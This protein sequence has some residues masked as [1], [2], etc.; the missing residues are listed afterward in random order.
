M[1]TKKVIYQDS[2]TTSRAANAL[3]LYTDNT[4]NL[5]DTRDQIYTPLALMPGCFT[6]GEHLKY[7][8]INELF[9]KA[10]NQFLAENAHDTDAKKL[11]QEITIAE[12]EQY[13][14]YYINGF[15]EW[16]I[17]KGFLPDLYKNNP[18]TVKRV[19][20]LYALVSYKKT[21][22]CPGYELYLTHY[23]NGAKLERRD[24]IEL[25][26]QWHEAVTDEMVTKEL[27]LN[28][29]SR[30]NKELPKGQKVEI[31]EY[32]YHYLLEV[33]PPNNWEGDYFEVGEPHHHEKGKAIHR[34]CWMEGDKYYTGYPFK[35]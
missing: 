5:V 18:W 11:I 35:R 4:P 2:G 9:Y 12:Q 13:F 17:E 22:G 16:L 25:I 33:L 7:R 27:E 8:I 1:K 30:W 3:I 15:Y 26:K 19:N 10:S 29:W 21:Q 20:E 24:E 14:T 23:Y 32:I 34:A 31:S 6:K 28:D